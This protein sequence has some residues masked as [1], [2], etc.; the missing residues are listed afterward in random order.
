MLFLVRAFSFVFVLLLPYVAQAM[1]PEEK[2]LQIARE[3]DRRSQ[4]FG[5]VEF[6]M[7]M[8]LTNREG[9]R[10]ERDL[11][12]RALEGQ[13]KV[14]GDR[15]LIV[16]DNPM[17]VRGMALLTYSY[18]DRTDDQWLYLPATKRVNSISSQ[19]KSGPFMGSE[20][21]FEDIQTAEV[22]KYTYRY[23]RDEPCGKLTCYMYQRFPKDSFS[24]YSNQVVWVDQQEYRVHKI[25][26]YDRKR[27][28]LKTLTV[29]GHVR[30]FDR[31]W[32]PSQMQMVNHQS[33]NVTQLQ[34]SNFRLNT[35]L[36]EQDF[37]RNS[38]MRA[39]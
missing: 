27:S 18:A 1:S 2:G 12:V 29:S 32:V 33:G 19:N 11:R 34:M 8:M 10:S 20:F 35:S 13:E 30:H 17:D 36:T 31:L 39:R 37:T 7:K 25:E 28:L 21:A 23:L 15:S 38:L 5:G 9:N 22:E 24:G 16:F 26:Y 3:Q 4:G 14:R 6:N